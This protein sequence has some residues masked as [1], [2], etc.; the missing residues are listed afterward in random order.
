MYLK[1]D[2]LLIFVFLEKQNQKN[3][4]EKAILQQI[5]FNI[6]CKVVQW[7]KLNCFYLNWFLMIRLIKTK[8]QFYILQFIV[9]NC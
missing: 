7:E 4:N 2:I 5:T 3:V 8:Q 9:K 1:I 6:F